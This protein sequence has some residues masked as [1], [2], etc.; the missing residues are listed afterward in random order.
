MFE[1]KY[2]K[3]LT[4][5]LAIGIIVIIGFLI[6][7]GVTMIYNNNMIE[8]YEDAAEQYQNKVT[9]LAQNTEENNTVT[10]SV[11]PEL[12][13]QNMVAGGNSSNQENE[14]YFQGHLVVGTI[15]IPETNL[16]SVILSE[17]TDETIE[18][19]VGVYD[20]V[21]LNQVGNTTIAGHNYR[22]GRFFANNKQLKEGDKI[23][24]TDSTGKKVTYSVYKTY[25]TSP[26]D[27]A[28][29]ERDTQGKREITLVTCTDDTQSRL[30]I[31]AKEQ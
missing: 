2:S 18:I 3:L 21:G 10:N 15:E 26:E 23:Y 17:V 29:L 28:H 31:L 14:T 24:I 6:Y 16:K 12:E 27:S 20:G 11:A 13:V 22:D 5:L 8:D 19:A 30:I 9:N 25:I 4:V 7:L 1:S